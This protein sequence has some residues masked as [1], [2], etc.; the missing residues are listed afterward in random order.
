M[1]NS[2][3]QLAKYSLASVLSEIS[4][5]CN[6]L[7]SAST[8]ISPQELTYGRILRSPLEAQIDNMQMKE[9]RDVS[10]QEHLAELAR[11]HEQL[12]AI[13]REENARSRAGQ[14]SFTIVNLIRAQPWQ[15]TGLW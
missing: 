15:V 9:T 8:T 14:R 6:F 4:F 12:K 3:S 7:P 13:A 10:H 5:T 1:P 2:R 11:R